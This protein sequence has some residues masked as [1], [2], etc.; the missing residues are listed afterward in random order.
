[1]KPAFNYYGGKVRLAAKIIPLIPKHLVY[2]EPFAGGLAVF[3]QKPLVG[4]AYY[5]EVVND[6]N[7]DIV[8]FYQVLRDQGEELHRAL[9]LTLYSRE[10]YE[11]AIGVQ[12]DG[13]EAV[14]RARR[15]FVNIRQS[16]GY[17]ING[18][19]GKSTIYP[20][21]PKTYYN[22]KKRLFA[23][24]E[25]FSRVYIENRDALQVIETWDSPN[26]FFYC[27]PPYP[28]T[29][30]GHYGGYSLGD[31]Q[32]L[33]N[34]LGNCQGS[35]MVSNYDQDNLTI[36]AG[37]EKFAFDSYSSVGNV[38]AKHKGGSREEIL[39]RRGRSAPIIPL[40][41]DVWFSRSLDIFQGGDPHIL[42]EDDAPDTYKAGGFLADL[43]NTK[44][45]EE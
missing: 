20:L 16:F 28:N 36:P 23:C 10:E 45:E 17:K 41:R 3:F 35:W 8:N 18:G 11:L 34:L 5:A 38:T 13:L 9:D 1:M 22:G 14:E 2:V 29:G 43:L 40:H 12:E 39:W 27:D 33:F 4:S 32:D 26:T 44:D 7:S 15:F 6:L 24:T 30:Q 37:V 19:W 31:L 42:L 21:H 25:R